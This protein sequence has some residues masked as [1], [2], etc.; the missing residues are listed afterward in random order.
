MN[1]RKFYKNYYSIDFG[2]DMVVHHIDEDRENN[3]IYNL[4]LLPSELHQRWHSIKR[5]C[6]SM[7]EIETIT[8]SFSMRSGSYRVAMSYLR[9]YEKVREDVERW[10]LY[11]SQLDCEKR[12]GCEAV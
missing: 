12:W 8:E 7:Q 3:E 1:Y 9:E 11:K 10:I 6:K 5:K 2:P 4:L